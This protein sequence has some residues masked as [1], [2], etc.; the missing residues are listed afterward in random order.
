MD[1]A[2]TSPISIRLNVPEVSG[3]IK[4]GRVFPLQKYAVLAADRV[5]V[6]RQIEWYHGSNFASMDS[7]SVYRGFLFLQT[8]L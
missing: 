1:T 2:V 7:L 4:R 8:I 5:A 3:I 6:D